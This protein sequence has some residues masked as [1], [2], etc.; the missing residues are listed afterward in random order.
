LCV[1]SFVVFRSFETIKISS[2][3]EIIDSHC[4]KIFTPN[5]VA[6]NTGWSKVTGGSFLNNFAKITPFKLKLRASAYF[7]VLRVASLLR[8]QTT[9]TGG[10]LAC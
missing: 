9:I 10:T 6:Q 1:H 5:F 2:H 8:P 7:M 4:S 3:L